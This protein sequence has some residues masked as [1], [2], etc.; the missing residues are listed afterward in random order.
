MRCTWCGTEIDNKE[1][2][3]E[4]EFDKFYFCCEE[5]KEKF[6][7]FYEQ[8][9]KNKMKF[10]GLVFLSIIGMVTLAI[11]Y[12]AINTNLI[13]YGAGAWLGII[14][15]GTLAK[16]PYATPQTNRAMGIEGSTNMVRFIGYAFLVLGFICLVMPINTFI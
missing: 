7:A 16:Y 5:D 13:P 4:K 9:Q 15:G 14:L 10:L 1:I 11:I 8:V 3:Y 2:C 12:A 6:I